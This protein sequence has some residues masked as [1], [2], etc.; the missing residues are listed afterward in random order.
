MRT[1]TGLACFFLF[2][3]AVF[4]QSDRG[5]TTGTIADPAGAVVAGAKVEARNVDTGT[6]YEVASTGTGNYTLSQ[7]PAGTY[8]VSI[9]VPGFKRFVRQN[10]VV[11]VAGTLRVDV[12][13]EVGS[14][15][16]S[17]TVN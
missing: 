7:L 16:E 11:Q 3:V 5:T 9:A 1:V 6:P 8:E 4:A 14:A 2:S 12:T 10:I 15:A 13:L 17:V